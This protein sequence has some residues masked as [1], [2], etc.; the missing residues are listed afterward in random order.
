M[1][2]IGFGP[3]VGQLHDEDHSERRRVLLP[4]QDADSTTEDEG[5][6]LL[7]LCRVGEEGVVEFHQPRG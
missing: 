5:L 4:P 3:V 6:A 1:L 2:G 7:D